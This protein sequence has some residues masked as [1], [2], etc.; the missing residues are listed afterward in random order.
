MRFAKPSKI[1]ERCEEMPTILVVGGNEESSAGIKRLLE[2]DCYRVT[3]A[4]AEEGAVASALRVRPDLLLLDLGRPPLETVAAARRLR[5]RAG[6][7][8]DVPVVAIPVLLP[9]TDGRD[10]SLRYNVH[11]TYL[12]EFE[13]LENLLSRLIRQSMG[14]ANGHW[15]R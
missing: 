3:V 7:T 1:V 8:R 9:G 6:L 2:M 13:Q 5:R 11:V 4:S 12:I 14:R 10:A 15:R